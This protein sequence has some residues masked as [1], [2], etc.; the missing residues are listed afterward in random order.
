MEHFP[1]ARD[2]PKI[3]A[4][5]RLDC[6]RL[7]KIIEAMFRGGAAPDV[8]YDVFANVKND[9][10]ITYIMFQR[11]T[12]EVEN[13]HLN[14]F[15]AGRVT[16]LRII[17]NLDSGLVIEDNCAL[18]TL[19]PRLLWV[20]SNLKSVGCRQMDNRDRKSVVSSNAAE[21]FSEEAPSKHSIR[22]PFL[23]DDAKI[24]LGDV[25][26]KVTHA[27]GIRSCP[28]CERRATRLNRWM[29]FHR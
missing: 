21:P 10:R 18:N 23:T 24:G 20:F 27:V 28:G 22:I 8:P 29:S 26:R 12:L 17:E 25:I 14:P 3:T 4:S 19:F 1:V 13:L 11:F 7:H 5:S 16:L 15:Y 6:Y 2:T 9:D